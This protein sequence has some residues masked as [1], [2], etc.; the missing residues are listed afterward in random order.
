MPSPLL[1]LLALQ[2]TPQA[3]QTPADPPAFQ[4]VP[5]AASTEFANLVYRIQDLIAAKNFEGAKKLIRFLPTPNIELGWDSAK[6][7]KERVR[8]FESARDDAIANFKA[9][10]RLAEVR[11]VPRSKRLQ[12][13]FEDKLATPPDSTFPLG[14]TFFY[15]EDEKDP[16]L[17]AVVGLHRG[18]PLVATSP[19]DIFNDVTRALGAASGLA[20]TPFYGGAMAGSDLPSPSRYDL[21][22]SQK[23]V[24]KNLMKIRQNLEGLVAKKI[25]LPSGRP[26]VFVATTSVSG[27]EVFEGDQVPIA[28]Q[29]TNN[30][31]APLSYSAKGD[32]GCI[33]VHEENVLLPGQ[34]WI[35]RGGVETRDTKGLVQKNVE[36]MTNDPEH[37]A[38]RVPVETTI[39][40]RFEFVSDQPDG[41]TADETGVGHF[42][43]RLNFIPGAKQLKA[44]QAAVIGV[45]GTVSQK[46]IKDASGALTGY[47]FDVT[48]PKVPPGGPWGAELNVLTDDE[49][50]KVLRYVEHVVKGIIAMPPS[51][52]LGSALDT[53]KDFRLDIISPGTPFKLTSVSCNIPGLKTSIIPVKNIG[54]TIKLTY[55]GTMTSGPFEGQV[56]ID[57]DNPKYPHFEVPVSGVAK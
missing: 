5:V 7:P 50:M 44:K 53:K 33:V 56:L 54:Y 8:A 34:T 23:F 26:S 29:I 30:G 42:S 22:S 20:T 49:N 11:V 1:L 2:T 18:N 3:T 14:S 57:T 36:F 51:L 52:F 55:D 6:I 10:F 41:I 4:T 40:P 47:R 38:F 9:G 25:S 32:C 19:D 28:I 35:V 21:S 43:V 12:I 46:E 48:L 45:R 39:K 15:S 17:E 24:L 27:G 16:W 13:D 37:A 31:D